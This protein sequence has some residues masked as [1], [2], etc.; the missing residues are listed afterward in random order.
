MFD[1]GFDQADGLKRLFHTPRGLQLH[2]LADTGSRDPFALADGL[3]GKLRQAGVEARI[4]SPG[5]LFDAER[6]PQQVLISPAWMA[7]LRPVS[8]IRRQ[9]AILMA[10]P[11]PER[12]P[13]LYAAIKR[14]DAFLGQEPLIV[15]WDVQTRRAGSEKLIPVCEQNLSRTVG[16]FLGRQ[17][18]YRQWRASVDGEIVVSGQPTTLEWMS[19]AVVHR[20]DGLA[21]ARP[22]WQN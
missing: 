2:L 8:T 20:L 13:T 19:M 11:V 1:L 17:L 22:L 4:A 16:R 14:L 21:P 5:G 7:D 15:L 18:E 10:R 12:L 6:E 3:A 9:H